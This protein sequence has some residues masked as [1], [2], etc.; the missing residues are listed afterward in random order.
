MSAALPSRGLVVVASQTAL[1]R[2]AVEKAITE[3]KAKDSSASAAVSTFGEV[4]GVK[5]S[6]QSAEQVRR[7]HFTYD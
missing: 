3:L 4:V 6:S 7:L 1:K 5:A 2:T